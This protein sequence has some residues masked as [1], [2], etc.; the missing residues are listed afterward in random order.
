MVQ[1]HFPTGMYDMLDE[2]E[3]NGHAHIISWCDGGVA[4]KIHKPEHMILLLNT[5][6]S[7]KKYESFLRQLQKYGFTRHTRGELAGIVSHPFL[8]KGKRFL[9]LRMRPRQKK[10]SS[11]GPQQETTVASS[12][13]TPSQVNTLSTM[14]ILRAYEQQQSYVRPLPQS[15][16][17][18][19]DSN[20]GS[21]L[22]SPAMKIFARP[23]NKFVGSFTET[24]RKRE[25][26]C[27]SPKTRRPIPHQAH[28]PSE[29]SFPTH[30]H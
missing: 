11:K 30:T 22:G 7:Q 13:T 5:Y 2:A 15:S 20:D 10:R 16:T 9:C 27:S 12:N 23:F 4:F 17:R 18:N 29:L 3:T 28:N 21:E 26:L 14:E 6:F 8:I 24:Q 19:L 25:S 1:T